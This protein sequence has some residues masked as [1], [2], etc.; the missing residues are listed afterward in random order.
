MPGE[1]G[2]RWGLCAAQRRAPHPLWTALRWVG[3]GG[4]LRGVAPGSVRLGD[5]CRVP[6]LPRHLGWKE[7]KLGALPPLAAS[8]S[9]LGRVVGH[10][11]AS[12]A[13]EEG[14]RRLTATGSL[15]PGLETDRF[16]FQSQ[17]SAW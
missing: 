2:V 3:R 6:G 13:L 16:R 10:G 8:C 9:P 11:G 7:G 5:S 1:R 15:S 12:R 14:A 4:G 17:L